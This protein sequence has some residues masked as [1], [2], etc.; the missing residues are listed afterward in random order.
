MVPLAALIT[1]VTC[2]SAVPGGPSR[3]AVTSTFDPRTAACAARRTGAPVHR[4]NVHALG[5]RGVRVAE[6]QRAVGADVVDVLLAIQVE[7][8]RSLSVADDGR[9]TANG[10]EGP[11]RTVHPAG[12]VF[13]NEA[14]AIAGRAAGDCVI[15]TRRISHVP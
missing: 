2:P 14:P 15:E 4:V 13:L 7:K 9:V 8:V 6:D 5:D 10:P 12:D 11:G 3:V 1:K